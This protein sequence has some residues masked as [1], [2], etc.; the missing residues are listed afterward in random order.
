MIKVH[1][2][3]NIDMQAMHHLLALSP[4]SNLR[5]IMMTPIR[6]QKNKIIATPLN[7]CVC[8][9]HIGRRQK[10]KDLLVENLIKIAGGDIHPHMS[11]S[12]IYISIHT[13]TKYHIIC[14]GIDTSGC[15]SSSG[16]PNGDSCA[17]YRVGN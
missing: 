10:M 16:C 2:H 12:P 6:L 14:S 1:T 5:I 7:S 4:R 11:D 3:N 15:R 9:L 8:L 17:L 13:F